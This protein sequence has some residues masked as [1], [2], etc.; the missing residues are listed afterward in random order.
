MMSLFRKCLLPAT[1]VFLLGACTAV[2][3][4]LDHETTI[5]ILTLNLHTYQQLRSPGVDEAALTEEQA[6]RRIGHY[7]PIFDRIAA[8]IA[9]LDPDIICLQEVGEWR[10]DAA[11]D[12]P[13]GSS[14]SNMVHQV[15][16]RLPGHGYQATMDWSHVGFGTWREGSAILSRHPV[17]RLDSRWVSRP[18]NRRRDLWK[19]R[20]I[21][22]ARVGVPGVGAVDV[23]SVHLGWWDDA[24]EPFA[25]Q[26]QR[27]LEWI[28]EDAADIVVLCGDFNAPA[29]GPAYE[30]ITA[31]SGFVDLYLLANPAGMFD[32]TIAGDSDGW[33]G[34]GQGQRIDYVLVNEG[35][36]LR[37]TAARR[38]FTS[39]DFGQVSDHLG[40]FATLEVA[41]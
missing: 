5:S 28:G 33:E 37:V 16:S 32:A 1:A 8:G 29:G 2:A 14:A 3:D 10:G 12:D 21:P 31:E 22:M 23:Y 41:P 7:A 18:G 35:S 39:D 13:F 15:L 34:T 4:A 27:L 17:L 36:G 38:V 20:N 9:S 19:S 11:A 26:F 24:E 6:W 25:E 40:V 30:M